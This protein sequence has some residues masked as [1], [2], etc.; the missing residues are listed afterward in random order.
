MQ[1]FGQNLSTTLFRDGACVIRPA[2]QRMQTF[3]QNLSTTLF[4]DGACVI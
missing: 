4:R 1:T 3:G 2:G